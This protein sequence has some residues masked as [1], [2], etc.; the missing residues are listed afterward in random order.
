AT[1]DAWTI[2]LRSG[3]EFSSGKTLD[4]DDVLFTLRKTL[5]PATGAA[6][7]GILSIVDV[8]NCAKVDPLTVRIKLTRGA[9]NLPEMLSAMPVV[10][11]DYTEKKPVG[12]GPYIAQNFQP[13]IRTDLVRN[14]NYWQSGK[15]YFDELTVMD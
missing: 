8:A 2:R 1:A 3:V 14:D 9:V 6:A 13:G 4:A 11:A 12:S 10:P 15:P 5:D 7:A